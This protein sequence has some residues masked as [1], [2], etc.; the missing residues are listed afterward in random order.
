MKNTAAR[1]IITVMSLLTIVAIVVGLF[2]HV[3]GGGRLIRRA[4]TV[5]EGE[6]YDRAYGIGNLFK[7][8]EMISDSMIF[9]EEV[10]EIYIEVDAADI[11]VE[12]GD[13]LSVEYKLPDVM[14]PA[15]EV[16]KGKLSFVS[17]LKGPFSPFD[18]GKG[19]SVEITVPEGTKLDSFS[20]NLDAGRVSAGSFD[21]GKFIIN[22]DAGDMEIEE[23]KVGSFEIRTDAGNLKISDLT[24]DRADLSLDAGNV[25]IRDSVIDFLEAKIDAGNIDADDSTINSG[26]CK[27]DFGNVSLKGKIGNVKVKSSVGNASVEGD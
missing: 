27:T 5:S 14:K 4:E 19:A 12:D 8:S 16:K 3:F 2:I 18:M 26:S 10:D 17:R 24:A 25:I 11:T 7:R 21:T 1:V 13:R 20:I 6:A 9:D 23:M 15:I 22:S